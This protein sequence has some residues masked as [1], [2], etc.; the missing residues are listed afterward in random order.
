MEQNIKNVL[1]ELIKQRKYTLVSEE[2]DR[3]IA[4]TAEKNHVCIFTN[5]VSEIN[6]SNIRLYKD[7]LE[8]MNINHG[9]IIY[10]NTITPT[11]KTAIHTMTVITELEI[12][13]ESE[14]QFNPTK[15]R[16]V[17]KMTALSSQEAKKFKLKYGIQI[18]KMKHSDPIAKF[19][20]WKKGDIIKIEYPQIDYNIVV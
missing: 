5:I 3:I 9:I 6:I 16:L 10:K 4:S 20:G 7:L 14:L 18:S 11:A 13:H 15:H 8:R 1:S 12:F 17:P 2:K 19:M